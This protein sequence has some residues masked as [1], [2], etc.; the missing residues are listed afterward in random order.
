[1]S[2]AISPQDRVA[3]QQRAHEPSMEEI[4]ASIRRIIADD[5][6]APARLAVEEAPVAAAPLAP[7]PPANLDIGAPA[8]PQAPALA[9][10]PVAAEPEVAAVFEAAPAAE[11]EE[12]IVELTTPAAAALAAPA[13]EPAA[14]R[15]ISRETDAAVAAQFQ[16]L[17]ETMMADNARRIDD[18]TRD[19]LR[20]MLKAWLDDNLP[21]LVEK[22]VRAEIERVA[23]GGR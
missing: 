19:L 8:R 22:L 11:P 4:L 6:R 9:I 10:E 17:A 15:L 7:D 18:M 14:A 5:Q 13:M 21:I 23:R 2:S 12:E 16:H 1:M 3:A 20:P